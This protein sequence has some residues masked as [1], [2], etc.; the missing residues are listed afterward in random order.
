MS[1]LISIILPVYNNERHLSRCIKS[2]LNQSHN[3]IE[4]IIVD[5]GSTDNS[6][7]VCDEFAL[8]D[9]RVICIHI[10]NSGVAKA[11]NIG[12]DRAK[13]DYLVFVDS[14]DY[15][16]P[17]LITDNL[18]IA[19][20]EDADIVCFNYYNDN[21]VNKIKVNSYVEN[22]NYETILEKFV[23]G[24]TE[25]ACW[26]KLYKRRIWNNLRFPVNINY[27][28]DWYTV[29]QAFFI[30]DKI[31]ANDRAYYYYTTYNEGSITH[32]VNVKA[33]YNN[34]LCVKK[35]VELIVKT[36]KNINKNI[37]RHCINQGYKVALKLYSMDLYWSFL[38]DEEKF[39][40]ESFINDNL[41]YRNLLTLKLKFYLFIYF[42]L[43][44]LLSLRGMLY[45]LQMKNKIIL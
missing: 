24:R 40:V 6:G 43:R 27:A 10:K 1:N 32:R 4:L 16:G 23:S 8:N 33:E 44:I 3:E 42:H 30:T 5:D 7:N 34:F 21:G 37:L 38:L 41:G 19:L 39:G 35:Q 45:F 12:I 28:E 36:Y 2:I 18:E 31:V 20:K 9:D 17:E 14:D 25:K 29:L 26:N 22:D 13:G 15:L 11:R